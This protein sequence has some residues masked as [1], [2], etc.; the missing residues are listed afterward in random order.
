MFCTFVFKIKHNSK[1][2][3]QN[4]LVENYTLTYYKIQTAKSIAD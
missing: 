4:K 3:S 2:F 1:T